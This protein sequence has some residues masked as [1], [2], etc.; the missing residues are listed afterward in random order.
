MKMLLAAM[1]AV[2][3]VGA[4]AAFAEDSMSK[5]A[6]AKDKMDQKMDKMD[7]KSDAMSKSSGKMKASGDMMDKKDGMSKDSMS[8]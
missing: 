7:H 3:L 6:M 2:G 1:I 4:P 5:P 8:K